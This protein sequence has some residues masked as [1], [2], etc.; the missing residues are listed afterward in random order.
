MSVAAGLRLFVGFLLLLVA[1]FTLRPLLGGP[2]PIDF[3]L[4]AVLFVSVHLR[5]GAAALL[6]FAVGTLTDAVAPES[7]GAGALALTLVGY[8]GGWLRAVFLADQLPLTALV[9]F[10][11]KWLFDAIY[12]L[13]GPA[14]RGVSLVLQLLL[15]S[16]LAAALTALVAVVMLV[17]FRPLFRGENG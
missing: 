6:G 15:W 2:A 7:F 17:L 13:V 9:V 10:G 4:I 11:G 14:K 3:L 12:V 1:H 8:A 16:P 5:P